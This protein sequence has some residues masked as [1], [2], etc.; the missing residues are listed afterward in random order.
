MTRTVSVCATSLLCYFVV[1]FAVFL[2]V[3]GADLRLAATHGL[4]QAVAGALAL[5][6]FLSWSQRRGA[7]ILRTGVWTRL[8]AGG[9][10]ALPYLLILGFAQIVPVSLLLLLMVALVLVGVAG[11]ALHLVVLPDRRLSTLVVPET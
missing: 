2:A 11:A 5:F 6:L 8:A 9:A 4:I 10:S 3:S 7:W 1:S